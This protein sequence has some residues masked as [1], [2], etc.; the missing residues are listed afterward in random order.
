ML[1]YI[2]DNTAEE[3]LGLLR[4]LEG[5]IAEQTEERKTNE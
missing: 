5:K 2:D 3:V 4:E 1:I